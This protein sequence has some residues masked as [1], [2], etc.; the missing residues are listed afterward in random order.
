M[1][2]ADAFICSNLNW[3]VF[4]HKS[5]HKNLITLISLDLLA[6]MC[7]LSSELFNP[8]TESLA[9]EKRKFSRLQFF[10]CFLLVTFR[11]VIRA[12]FF[13]QGMRSNTVIISNSSCCFS[14]FCSQF[15]VKE[16][17]VEFVLQPKLTLMTISLEYHPFSFFFFFLILISTCTT[18]S[19]ILLVLKV[20]TFKVLDLQSC[21]LR[22]FSEGSHFP[23]SCISRNQISF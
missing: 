3:F 9:Q 13:V 6:Y 16:I 5:I 12:L 17:M 23:F 2:T 11:M 14:P 8:N 20:H 22:N 4:I 19:S 15:C 7:N 10:L 18:F 21:R 1:K